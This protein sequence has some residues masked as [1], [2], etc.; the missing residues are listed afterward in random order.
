[1]SASA[2]EPPSAT[3]DVLDTPSAGALA[4]RGSALRGLG[5][6]VGTLLTLASA[7][8]LVRHLG[9][10]DFGRYFTVISLI[11][12]V[13]GVTD[14][15]LAT[16]A[17]REYSVRTGAAR[18]LFMREIAGLRLVLTGTGVLGAVA[19]TALAGYGADLVLGTALAGAGLLLT[20]VAHTFSIPLAVHLR[21]GWLT[22]V[23]IGVKALGVALVVALVLAS[24]G[25]VGFLAIAIPTS[26]VALAVNLALTRGQMPLRPSLRWTELWR[27][28]RETL[29][30]AVATVLSTL[31]ARVVI[32]VM[33]LTATGLTTG[34]FGT[35]ARVMEAAVGMPLA[36][37]GTTFPI[38]ARAARDDEGRLRYVVQRVAEVALIVGVWMTLV[39]TVGADAISDVL[40]GGPDAEPVGDVLR[41]LALG[42][43]LI[44]LNVT[45]QTA[46][47]ALR[48]HAR[49]RAGV[50]C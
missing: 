21:I 38:F 29:T 43:T 9:V 32:L 28:L 44:F 19:F 18:D 20:V 45:W 34:Y 6:A 47:V 41:I 42:L 8:L 11:A 5:Y 7:P 33:S 4:I 48:L 23:D 10:V 40:V 39:I 12:V 24:A 13:G 31:Y 36:L 25:V 22:L 50:G 37:V 1:V 3:A 30:L 14:I 49:L 16:V 2:T 17:L 27:L 35:A 46:M 15:G 26:I